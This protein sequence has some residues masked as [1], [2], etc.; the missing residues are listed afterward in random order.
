MIITV[1]EGGK[2]V[3]PPSRPRPPM[4]TAEKVG[5]GLIIFFGILIIAALTYATYLE[6]G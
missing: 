1:V 5:I 4:T 2:F 6:I 3:E